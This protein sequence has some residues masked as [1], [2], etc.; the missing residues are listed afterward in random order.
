M[1]LKEGQTL[2]FSRH[3]LSLGNTGWIQTL[4]RRVTG[5]MLNHCATTS[6]VYLS[7]MSLNGAHSMDYITQSWNVQRT[8]SNNISTNI[9]NIPAWNESKEKK[10][11]NFYCMEGTEMRQLV[12]RSADVYCQNLNN[13]NLR[14]IIIF[15]LEQKEGEKGKRPERQRERE[16]VCV[17]ERR[18]VAENV[19]GVCS[20]N[21][22]WRKD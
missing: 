19:V 15:I 4:S 12:F 10:F 11:K 8:L 14:N 1:N 2:Y 6:T 5:W 9:L 3:L 17:C 18:S 13:L 21:G 7:E 22:R 16:R 20:K